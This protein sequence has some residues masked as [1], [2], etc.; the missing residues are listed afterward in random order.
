MSSSQY[1]ANTTTVSGASHSYAKLSNYNNGTKI[2][3][4]PFPPPLNG[5]DAGTYI[6]PSYDLPGYNS[7]VLGGYGGYAKIGPAYKSE[8]GSCKIVYRTMQCGSM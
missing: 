2:L 6:V 8:D 1:E 5:Q 4:L 3:N 7:L